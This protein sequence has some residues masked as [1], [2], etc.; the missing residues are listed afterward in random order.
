MLC[1]R[2]QRDV[3]MMSEALTWAPWQTVVPF[4]GTG[5]VDDGLAWLC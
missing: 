1:A 4:T 3:K 2:P 5:G